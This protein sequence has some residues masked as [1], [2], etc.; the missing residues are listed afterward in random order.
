MS[1]NGKAVALPTGLTKQLK[2]KVMYMKK[3]FLQIA[4][5]S[6]LM[7]NGAIADT[8]GVVSMD[9]KV[10]GKSLGEYANLWWQW[11]SSMPALESPVKDMTGIKCD[12]NQ[13]GQVWFLAGGYGS[14][15][16]TRKCSIP[17]GNH[18]FFPVIN[19]LYFPSGIGTSLTC[20]AAKA[21]V[22]INNDYLRSFIV[23]I[24]KHKIVNPV[25]HRYSTPDC[26]DLLGWPPKNINSPTVYPSATDGYWVMLKPLSL[27]THKIKFRAEYHNQNEDYG[28]MIQDIEYQIDIIESDKKS[29]TLKLIED[30]RR[31]PDN[32]I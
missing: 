21:S 16:I 8:N 27:G 14:S 28:M 20:D 29:P 5:L 17:K 24:D 10:F 31:K 25:L 26:F 13:K 15:K 11:A 1:G 4:V 22:T 19:M 23:T 7:S 2:F 9:E 18:L 3:I 30:S 32:G 6:C 12:V